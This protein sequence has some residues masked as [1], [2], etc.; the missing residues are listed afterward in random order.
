[1]VSNFNQ[2]K[3]KMTNI[4]DP[5]RILFVPPKEDDPA[6]EFVRRAINA[7]LRVQDGPILTKKKTPVKEDAWVKNGDDLVEVNGFAV[8]PKSKVEKEM[9]ADDEADDADWELV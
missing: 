1:M 3:A 5:K 4:N 7:G 8:V 2:T 9:R 6:Q